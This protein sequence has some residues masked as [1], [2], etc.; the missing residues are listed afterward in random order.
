MTAIILAAADDRGLRPLTDTVHKALLP[1]GHSTILGSFLDA[2]LAA[3]IRDVVIVVGHRADDIRHYC[4]ATYPDLAIRF[5]SVV[6]GERTDDVAALG[7]ALLAEPSI[8]DLLVMCVDGLIGAEV[9]A[10]AL[11]GPLDAVMVSTP[12]AG[13]D[14]SADIGV[15]R[16]SRAVGESLVKSIDGSVTATQGGMAAAVNAMVPR[17]QAVT[18][19]AH[20][21]PVHS[22]NDIEAARFHFE[23]SSRAEILDRMGGGRWNLGVTDFST[24]Y[25][26]RYPTP[27]MVEAMRNA[28]PSLLRSQSSTQPVLNE[29]LAWYLGCDAGRLQVL[30]GSS[31]IQPIFKRIVGTR[32]VL[33]PSPTFREYSRLYPGAPVFADTGTIDLESLHPQVPENGVVLFVSP[34]RPTG[35]VIGTESMLRFAEQHPHTSFIIDESFVDFSDETPVVSRL[36]DEFH[37]NIVVIKSLS[38]VCGVPG[39]RLGYIYCQNP[40]LIRV[41]YDEIPTRNLG[42]QAEHFLELLL[43][44]RHDLD[45]SVDRTRE[46]RSQFAGQLATLRGISAVHPSGGN[47]LMLTL[48]GDDPAAGKRARTQLL[49]RFAI[50]VRDVS[51]TVSARLCV[52]VRLPVENSLFCDALGA[53]L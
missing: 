42:A 20:W 19:D 28:L 26:A 17:L 35:T 51:N 37:P 5:V 15:F 43:A 39:L 11:A 23:P 21:M 13:S 50:D 22:P 10:R 6:D 1:I 29:K 49:E 47:F 53:V 31:Q 41:L 8:D 52:A 16:F 33:M 32:P 46:D 2:L 27:A 9:I 3:S 36:N 7:R 34:N 30:H 14:A 44:F 45:E 48:A 18:V 4:A 38:A 25:N 12:Q 24:P 40:E